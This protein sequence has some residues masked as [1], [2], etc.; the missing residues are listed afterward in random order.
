MNPSRLIA[1]ALV[2]FAAL[3]A[4]AFNAL[5]HKTIAALAWQEL[6]PTTQA[7][8]VATLRRHPRFDEDFVKR[9]LA[10][11]AEADEGEWIFQHAATWPDLVRGLP[12]ETRHT[13]DRPSWHY[14]NFP[15]FHKAES[16]LLNINLS[17]DY[18]TP[19]DKAK[20]NI[21]QAVKAC[22]ASLRSKAPPSEKALAYCWLFHL[23]G[24][25]HQPLHSSALFSDRFPTGDRG[26]NLIET[27]QGGNLH[28]L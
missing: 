24:D 11:L 25:A 14:V 1:F 19:L 22:D 4:H 6:P 23:V 27:A 5:G 13:Y 16:P 26:G 15:I 3:P 28:S 10:G 20:W 7:H 21:I 9:Q 2:L 12:G 8:I 18:P 17:P